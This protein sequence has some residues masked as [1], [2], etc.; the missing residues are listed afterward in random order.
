MIAAS[1]AKPC[2]TEAWGLPTFLLKGLQRKVCNTSGKTWT[3]QEPAGS[4]RGVLRAL[5]RVG[6]REVS[7]QKNLRDWRNLGMAHLQRSQGR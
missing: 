2:Q 6:L 4:V 3:S 7:R 1:S 5:Q